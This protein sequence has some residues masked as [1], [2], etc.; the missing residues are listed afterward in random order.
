MTIRN[1]AETLRRLPPEPAAA[2]PPRGVTRRG[3]ITGGLKLV[4]AGAVIGPGTGAYA[5]AEAANQLI[6][7]D[8][9]LTPPGWRAAI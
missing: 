9:R 6:V 1:A 8:Y 3:L 5:A 2:V 4:G 7:T